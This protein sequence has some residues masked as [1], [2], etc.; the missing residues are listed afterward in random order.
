[1]GVGT[2]SIKPLVRDGQWYFYTHFQEVMLLI[3]I[4]ITRTGLTVDGHA[5]YAEIGNDIICAA[6]SAFPQLPILVRTPVIPGFNDTEEEIHK[7]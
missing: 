7:I 2:R 6:A 3:V 1:M 5:G 4:N